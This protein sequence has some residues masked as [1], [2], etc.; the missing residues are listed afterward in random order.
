MSN[1]VIAIPRLISRDDA[2]AIL[3]IRP[4]TLACWACNGRYRLPFVRVGRRV[5]YRRED[6]EQFISSNLVG[7]EAA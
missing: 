4:H 5:M 6:I 3:G 2:A 7:Q 1:N